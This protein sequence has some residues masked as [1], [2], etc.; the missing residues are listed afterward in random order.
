MR[1]GGVTRRYD[2]DAEGNRMLDRWWP[3]NDPESA[4]EQS[5]RCYA[6]ADLTLLLKGTGLARTHVEP[7]GTVYE[8]TGQFVP[9]APLAQAMSYIAVLNHDG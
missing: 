7:L 2:F 9:V 4:V 3:A 1:F 8:T 5:L 6:P